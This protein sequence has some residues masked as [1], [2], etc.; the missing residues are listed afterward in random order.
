MFI[1]PALI[2]RF[3]KM[4]NPNKPSS[5]EQASTSGSTAD[6]THSDDADWMFFKLISVLTSLMV[7]F[8]SFKRLLRDGLGFMAVVR[9][10]FSRSTF[11]LFSGVMC[12]RLTGFNKWST[13]G[14]K[15]KKHVFVSVNFCK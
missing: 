3:K 7:F 5:L 13:R 2:K 11:R 12:C 6:L 8:N 10:R 1:L 4:F 14:K 9:S 15:K